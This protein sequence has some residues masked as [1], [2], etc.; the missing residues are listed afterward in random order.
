MIGT[1]TRRKYAQKCVKACG[2][3]VACSRDLCCLRHCQCHETKVATTA[4]KK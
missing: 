4:V 1:A 2:F 3:H